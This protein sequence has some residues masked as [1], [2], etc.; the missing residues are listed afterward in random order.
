V[1]S[2]FAGD[3]HNWFFT[4]SARGYLFSRIG[5]GALYGR[6]WRNSQYDF[7]PDVSQNSSEGRVFLTLAI[8]RWY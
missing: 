4:A 2:G 3:H 7:Q 5:I 8:P 1:L 6:Y